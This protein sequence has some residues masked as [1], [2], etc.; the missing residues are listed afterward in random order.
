MA[1]LQVQQKAILAQRRRARP[2]PTTR[3]NTSQ[4][5]QRQIAGVLKVHQNTAVHV[6]QISESM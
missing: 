5:A 6:S 4:S 3:G 2:R 1:R